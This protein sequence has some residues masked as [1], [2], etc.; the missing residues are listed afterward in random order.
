MKTE[1]YFL[2]SYF[3][4]SYT[5]YLLLLAMVEHHV[6]MAYFSTYWDTEWEDI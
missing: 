3:I 5:P 4:Y 1:G 6:Q 2:K